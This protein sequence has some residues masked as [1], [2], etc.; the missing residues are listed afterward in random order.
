MPQQ[1]AADREAANGRLDG[2]QAVGVKPP[3]FDYIVADT[4]AEAVAA[5]AADPDAKVL[6]GGQS[7]V[8]MLAFRLVRPSTLIDLARIPGLANVEHTGDSLQIGATARQLAVERSA[9]V[10]RFCPLIVEGLQKVSHPQIRSR[11]TVGGSLAHADP[12]AELPAVAV[13]L[14]AKLTLTGVEGSR[15]VDARDFFEGVFATALRPGEILVTATFPDAPEGSGAACVEIARRPG[16]YALC[17]AVA[18][19][20]LRDGV[21]VECRLALFGI[22]DRPVRAE[23][24]E[25]AIQG[26]TPTPASLRE[27]GALAREGLEPFDDVHATA[28]YRL[29]VVAAV[30]ERALAQALARA[31]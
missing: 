1:H 13:A 12:A 16:D 7:L 3:L 30:A 23:A 6:A 22:G 9:V 20:T 19:V 14:D 15:V 21:A 2:N 24:V 11:A 27:A 10:S 26:T 28:A 8:P 18:Q 17:G 25:A 29:E 31:A 5:L 4:V